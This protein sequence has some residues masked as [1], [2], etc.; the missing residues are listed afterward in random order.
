MKF[1][2]ERIGS[3]SRG[4]WVKG[5]LNFGGGYTI[6]CMCNLKNPDISLYLV[7]KEYDVKSFNQS[8]KYNK[9]VYSIEF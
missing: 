3:N 9:I 2:I 7:D 8:I 4:N 6:T 5:T 1:K